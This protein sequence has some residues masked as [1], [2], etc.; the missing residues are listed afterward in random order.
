M[1]TTLRE[2]PEWRDAIRREL[3]T[4]ELLEFPAHFQQSE[5]ERK[6]D[7]RKVWE[8]IRATNATLKSFMES[9]Q[10]FQRSME[11]FKEA[12]DR[13]FSEV[14]GRLDGLETTLKSFME[15]TDRRFSEV[16]GRLDSLETT[17]KSFM[18]AT[19]RSFRRVST[20]LTELDG[21]I[22]EI[23]ALRKLGN[24]LYNQMDGVELLDQRTFNQAAAIALKAG[25]I[26]REERRQV[27]RADA[28]AA[29]EDAATGEPACAAVEASG[30]VQQS[31]VE[32]AAARSKL[33]FKIL[34]AAVAAKPA[35]FEGLFPSPPTKTFALVVGREITDEARRE[36]E[37]KGVFFAPYHNGYEREED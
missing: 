9:T 25:V 29:G 14:E 12:T 21:G 22:V 20:K 5:A 15:A 17:L 8:A 34:Q 1:L 24:Y 35:K 3:L 37:R 6:E 26:S 7:Q 4:E 13:R 11:E 16:E 33:L 36:A 10:A 19:E 30:V 31:D 32:R 23:R 2:H 28:L 27:D 18:E